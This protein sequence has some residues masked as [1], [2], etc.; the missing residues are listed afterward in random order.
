M[1][2]THTWGIVENIEFIF[3]K[4]YLETAPIGHFVDECLHI[5][6]TYSTQT[7]FPNSVSPHTQSP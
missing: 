1:T 6:H 5:H 4:L 3:L 2:D 7:H